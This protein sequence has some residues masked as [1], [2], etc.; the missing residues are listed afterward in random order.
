LPIIGTTH[1]Q[2]SHLKEIWFPTTNDTYLICS[3]D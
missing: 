2:H 1:N 3:P